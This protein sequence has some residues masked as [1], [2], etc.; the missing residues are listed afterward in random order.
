ML[1]G[2]PAVTTAVN[3]NG[4]GNGIKVD[5]GMPLSAKSPSGPGLTAHGTPPPGGCPHGSRFPAPPEVSETNDN[6]CEMTMTNEDCE[7]EQVVP[8]SVHSSVIEEAAQK[9]DLL[10]N[11]RG[12]R[13]RD[14]LL[15]KLNYRKKVFFPRPFICQRHFINEKVGNRRN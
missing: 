10:R 9:V 7:A 8:S 5:S 15:L 3:S 4:N 1:V 6:N 12:I 2:A 14:F 13:Y 11:C